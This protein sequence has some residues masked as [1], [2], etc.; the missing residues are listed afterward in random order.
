MLPELFFILIITLLLV[1][2]LVPFGGYG[3]HRDRFSGRP[4]SVEE[5]PD[6]VD[7]DAGVGI[8]VTMVFFF[9][10]LFPLI[11]AGSVWVGP[12]GPMFM[13]VSWGPIVAIG[14]ILALMLAAILPR[15]SKVKRTQSQ[16]EAARETA[17]GVFGVFF[18]LLI[19]V[20]LATV[21]IGY[22]W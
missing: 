2:L 4:V 5:E 14:F 3:T 9:F 10:I 7:A 16:E 15:R 11:F 17:V 20:A 19:F 13:G 1:T 18:F 12:R 6:E 22:N 8:G 21:V